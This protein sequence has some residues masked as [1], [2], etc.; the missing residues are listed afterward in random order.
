MWF[1]P[2]FMYHITCGL[3]EGV[4]LTDH[5]WDTACACSKRQWPVDYLWFY[6]VS[7]ANVSYNEAQ[8]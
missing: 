6:P 4:D 3:E 2:F 5:G 7:A 1:S 8:R